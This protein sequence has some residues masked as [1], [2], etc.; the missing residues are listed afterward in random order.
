MIAAGIKVEEYREIKPSWARFFVYNRYA[1]KLF[2]KIKGQYYDPKDVLI[3]F[4]NG[5]HPG[6]RQ[7]MVECMGLVVMC[8]RPGWGAIPEKLY[9]TIHLGDITLLCA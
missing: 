5:Y 9:Y 4:S 2:I 8:G 3:C 7:M 6:R 1:D